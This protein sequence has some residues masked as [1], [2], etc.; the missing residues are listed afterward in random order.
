MSDVATTANKNLSTT[1]HFIFEA[2]PDPVYTSRR[3][4]IYMYYKQD[5]DD[6]NLGDEIL[7]YKQ[8]VSR[9][10]GVWYADG[11]YIGTAVVGEYFGGGNS[12]KDVKTINPYSW[13]ATTATIEE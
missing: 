4:R 2:D 11:T 1:L 10:D 6:A 12:G 7:V 3:M 13:K 9:K 8:I 5:I